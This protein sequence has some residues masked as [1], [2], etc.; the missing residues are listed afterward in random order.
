MLQN[1]PE[2]SS[3]YLAGKIAGLSRFRAFLHQISDGSFPAVHVH[4]TAGVLTGRNYFATSN[5]DRIDLGGSKAFEPSS[6]AEVRRIKLLPG[7]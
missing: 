5:W 1:A 6:V 2:E 3:F 4:G 7:N